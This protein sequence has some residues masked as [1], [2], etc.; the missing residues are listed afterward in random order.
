[1]TT[2]EKRAAYAIGLVAVR[3]TK[4][5]GRRP[6]YEDKMHIQGVSKALYH[7]IVELPALVEVDTP[8][9]RILSYFGTVWILGINLTVVADYGY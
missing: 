3:T 8:H 4:L 2:A 1:M 5:S 6:T 9:A 7:I